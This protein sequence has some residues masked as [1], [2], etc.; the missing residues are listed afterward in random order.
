MLEIH[1]FDDQ[2]TLATALASAV[3]ND[4]RAALQ[5]QPLAT[6]AVSGG[7]SPVP[8]FEV[9]REQDLDW[10]RVI[11]TLVDE[12]WVPENDPASNEALVRSHLL[13]DRAAAARFVPLYTGAVSAE[14]AEKILAATFRDLPLPFAAVILGLGDDGHTASLFPGSPHLRE[15]LALGRTVAETPP[16]LAQVGAVAPTERI[17][18]TLPWTLYARRIYLQFAG[19]AKIEVF[20]TAQSGPDLRYPVSF[21]LHQTQTSVAVF[22]A[23]R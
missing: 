11:V 2:P 23:R 21:V 13:Q 5:D 9:L 12:R 10:P 22:A 20:E 18:L 1:W 8:V 3:A 4:L 14:A 15:G 7:R 19:A 16:C 17:S 6:L